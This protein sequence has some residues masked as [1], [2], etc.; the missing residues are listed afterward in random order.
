MKKNSGKKWWERIFSDY[1]V[2]FLDLSSAENVGHQ[3][4]EQKKIQIKKV[5]NKFFS[6]FLPNKKCKVDI[7][8]FATH[9]HNE[10]GKV[11]VDIF[12]LH[13]LDF[14][15]CRGPQISIFFSDLLTDI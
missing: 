12:F 9:K 13:S 3:K 10:G 8:F 2:R 1:S 4:S 7:T 11:L 6:F 15:R 5:S 14:T